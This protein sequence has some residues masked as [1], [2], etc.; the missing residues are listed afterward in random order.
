MIYQ[1]SND[2]LKEAISE[3]IHVL[4][5]SFREIL[6]SKYEKLEESKKLLKPDSFIAK[7]FGKREM[8]FGEIPIVDQNDLSSDTGRLRVYSSPLFFSEG[9]DED[10]KD[11]IIFKYGLPYSSFVLYAIQDLPIFT[12]MYLTKNFHEDSIDYSL[13]SLIA[14][15]SI[16]LRNMV[17]TKAGLYTEEPKKLTDLFDDLED[18]DLIHF[19]NDWNKII[20]K[21]PTDRGK[22]ILRNLP[23]EVNVMKFSEI[24]EIFEIKN[25][26]AQN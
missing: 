16:R 5:Y 11:R 8:G 9:D 10:N 3:K 15:F 22:D 19:C 25:K 2:I 20:S 1:G 12:A 14:H 4:D 24:D 17:F 6:G 21:V 18:K 26:M 7:E 13:R 23:S